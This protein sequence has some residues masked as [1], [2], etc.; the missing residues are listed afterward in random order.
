MP[1]SKSIEESLKELEQMDTVYIPPRMAAPILK[2]NPYSITLQARD[3]P[4]KL[5][6][7][8]TVMGHRTRIHREAF[9]RFMRTGSA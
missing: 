2:V 9:I 7:P 4:S 8:V 5:G 6:F 3:D 1:L